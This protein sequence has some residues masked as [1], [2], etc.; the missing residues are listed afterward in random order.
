[1][2]SVTTQQRHTTTL[3]IRIREVRGSNPSREGE[4]HEVC[5]ILLSISHP[6]RLQYLKLSYKDPI[7]LLPQFTIH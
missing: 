7:T 3:L 4:Y 6:F 1:M 2:D 5:T